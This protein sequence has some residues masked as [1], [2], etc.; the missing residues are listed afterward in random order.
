MPQKNFR[1]PIGLVEDFPKPYTI[2]SKPQ[3][4]EAGT[5]LLGFK[6][7]RQP[8][9]LPTATPSPL[10]SSQTIHN[11][12]FSHLQQQITIEGVH[13]TDVET[14]DLQIAKNQTF[15]TDQQSLTL[16]PFNT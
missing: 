8:I 5:I 2:K 6:D 13:P 9:L 14:L 12:I 3:T 4:L 11:R 15:Q 7:L 10:T 1:E 16:S